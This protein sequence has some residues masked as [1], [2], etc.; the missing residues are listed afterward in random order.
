M[1]P[2]FKSCHLSLSHVSKFHSHVS[3]FSHVSKF[4]SCPNTVSSFNGKPPMSGIHPRVCF[5]SIDSLPRD[6]HNNVVDIISDLPGLPPMERSTF[7]TMLRVDDVSDTFLSLMLH[8]FDVLH[9]YTAVL[10]NSYVELEKETWEALRLNI[11]PCV[12]VSFVG[13]T[14]PYQLLL[15][16]APSSN[17]GVHVEGSSLPRENFDCIEWLD[18]MP[19]RSVLYISF[20]SVFIPPPED[21]LA[22]STAILDLKQPFLWVVREC[23][24]APSLSDITPDN[25]VEETRSYGLIVP[26]APQLHVLSHPSIGAFLSHCGWN[27]TLE[28]ISLGIPMIPY[29]VMMDQVTNAKFV[30]DI[31]KIGL[32]I[33]SQ[34]DM[35]EKKKLEINDMKYVLR[36]L[37]HEEEGRY[38]RKR[39]EDLRDAAR[40]AI[41]VGGTS[42]DDI[43]K[44]I[45]VVRN[46]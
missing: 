35:I 21:L 38:M 7:P 44:F 23:V 34:I 40:K 16:G 3:S 36:V 15:D 45:Q 31:W 8:Q 24:S 22:I 39:A 33:K 10:I 20:G 27:S 25:F 18:K 2:K 37:F 5:V 26:W 41:Q 13:P 14:C 6:D 1:S 32:R 29:P 9:E 30:V 19:P 12:L 43:E 4:K 46:T 28:S 17:D 11:E 42:H